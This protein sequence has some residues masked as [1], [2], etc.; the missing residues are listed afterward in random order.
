MLLNIPIYYKDNS[1]YIDE[2][3]E[4]LA[5]ITEYKAQQLHEQEKSKAIE[6]L[7]E[8][9]EETEE[10]LCELGDLSDDSANTNEDLMDAVTELGDLVAA[11]ADTIAQLQEIIEQLTKAE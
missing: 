6:N 11:Q 10:A 3:E 1:L 9:I 7:P 4:N 5:K 8:T 2:T